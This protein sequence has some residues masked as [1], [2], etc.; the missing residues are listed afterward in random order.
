MK[1]ETWAI[2]EKET[3]IVLELIIYDGVSEYS[4]PDT[5]IL[6]KAPDYVRVGW[7]YKQDGTFTQDA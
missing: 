4:I 6:V 1:I 3:G 7:F 5:S 2:V